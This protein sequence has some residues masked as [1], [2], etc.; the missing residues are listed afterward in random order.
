MGIL[1]SITLVVLWT[2]RR[3]ALPVFPTI[4]LIIF[5]ALCSIALAIFSSITLIILWTL[6][7]FPMIIVHVRSIRTAIDMAPIAGP[8]H[9]PYRVS[10]PSIYL[11]NSTAVGAHPSVNHHALRG[12]MSML[13]IEIHS[14]L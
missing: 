2:L 5:L 7:W 14:K 13:L 4:T 1:P 9:I 12:E 6:R 8:I 10:L 11:A 3:V